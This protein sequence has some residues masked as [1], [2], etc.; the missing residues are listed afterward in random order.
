MA[1]SQ[2]W[3]QPVGWR[4]K[5]L[6]ISEINPDMDL[7]GTGNSHQCF[8]RDDFFTA[9]N[10]PNILGIE[11]SSLREGLLGEAGPLTVVAN[12]LSQHAPVPEI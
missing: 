12:G 9:L 6:Q 5:Q 8:N 7:R 2:V 10:F 3:T 4:V 1:L 11:S